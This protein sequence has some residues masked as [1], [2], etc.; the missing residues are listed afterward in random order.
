MS[1]SAII[2]VAG[3][4]TPFWQ[5][6][7][8]M[9]LTAI[10]KPA[11]TSMSPA[12]K[13][14]YAA[15][16]AIMPAAISAAPVPATSP[17]ISIE[18]SAICTERCDMLIAMPMAH[19]KTAKVTSHAPTVHRLAEADRKTGAAKTSPM[20]ASKVAMPPASAVP[21]LARML[22]TRSCLSLARRG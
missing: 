9:A 11:T 2:I 14:E 7:L 8:L 6:N 20:P 21:G 12:A 1:G 18:H 16:F 22:S 17:A 15:S 10:M 19:A 5:E 4:S 13:H 3:I